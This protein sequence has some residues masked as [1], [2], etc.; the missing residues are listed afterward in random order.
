MSTTEDVAAL[1]AAVPSPADGLCFCT[2]S[3]GVRTDNDLPT[4]VR[5]FA[6]RIY[7]IHLRNTR[8]G[9]EGNFYEANHLKGD[10]DAYAVMRELVLTMRT[11]SLSLPMRPNHGHQMLDDLH[12]KINPTTLPSTA[13]AG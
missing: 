5:Q 9:A 1:V 2:G 6:D 7:F 3:L 13:C 12:K 11:R 10:V 4:M 8:R